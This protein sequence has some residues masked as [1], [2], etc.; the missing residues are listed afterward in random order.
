MK[1]TVAMIVHHGILLLPTGS[2]LNTTNN[3]PEVGDAV[4]DHQPDDREG[5]PAEIKTAVGD[6]GFVPLLDEMCIYPL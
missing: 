3:T 2:K 5:Q 6:E 1:H 4:A